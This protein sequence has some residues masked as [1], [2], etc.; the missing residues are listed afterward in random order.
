MTDLNEAL[1]RPSDEPA[2]KPRKSLTKGPPVPVAAPTVD[3]AAENAELKARLDRMEQLLAALV[4]A[5]ASAPVKKNELD[6]NRP[7]AKTRTMGGGV[8]F[9]QDGRTF[10]ARGQLM[11]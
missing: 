10:N 1:V 7:Y 8:T 6:Q 4:P 9:E 2:K 11:A 5:A 3:L